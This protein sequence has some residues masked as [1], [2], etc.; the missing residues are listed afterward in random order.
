MVWG[1]YSRGNITGIHENMSTRLNKEQDAVNPLNASFCWPLVHVPKNNAV[2]SKSKFTF[3][4]TSD[5]I[6]VS[7]N[8]LGSKEHPTSNE[9]QSKLNLKQKKKSC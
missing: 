4:Y 5:A 9:P 2:S 7:I 1:I 8:N 6:V 3:G